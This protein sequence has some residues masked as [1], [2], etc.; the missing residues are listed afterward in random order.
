MYVSDPLY[1][2]Q[3]KSMVEK[4]LKGR[5]IKDENVLHVMGE[6]P[7]ELFVPDHLKD[8]VYSDTALPIGNG[9]TISQPYVVAYMTEML[10]LKG[11]EKVL[12]IGTGSG[13]QAAILSKLSKE[14]YTIERI[15]ELAEEAKRRFDILEIKNIKVF[16]KDG[17]E[18]LEE[19][20][21]FDRVI[22][23]AAAPDIPPPLMSQLSEEGILIAPV[24]D[25]LSQ[26]II[27][28]IK[29]DGKISKELLLPVIFVPLISSYGISR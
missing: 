25:Y 28:I 20:A 13:Y 18:G 21:P 5:G 15:P 7:R 29:K 10:N 3:R 26:N 11:D 17:T 1:V 23:T 2:K 16:V 22:V 24:G 14:V 27:K 9:Q 4:Q 12:E 19:Y 8:D 6:I